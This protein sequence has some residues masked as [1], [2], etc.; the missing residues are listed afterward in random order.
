LWAAIDRVVA[1]APAK[2]R[3]RLLDRRVITQTCGGRPAVL[4]RLCEMFRRSVPAHVAAIRAALDER[5]FARL[6]L[7]AHILAG[8]LSAFSTI[9]GALASTLEDAA[10]DE[11]LERCASLVAQLESTC[12]TLLE[13]TRGL[14]LETLDS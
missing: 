9:A 13:E 6:R 5:D 2:Q 8:T 11:D 10:T 4:E 7:A 12:T 3:S 1:D 14:T